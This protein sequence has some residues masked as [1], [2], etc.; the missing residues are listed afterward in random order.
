MQQILLIGYGIRAP[1]S[2]Q[3]LAWT[4]ARRSILLID[5]DVSYPL[6]V[7]LDAWPA[8]LANPDESYPLFLWGSISEMLADTQ[9][10]VQVSNDGPIVI[11]IAVLVTEKETERYWEEIL[12]GRAYPATDG[13]IKLA[14]EY[15]GFDVADRSFVSGLTNCIYSPEELGTLRRDWS[16]K[17]NKWGLFEELG[18]AESFRHVCDRLAPEHAPFEAYRIRKINLF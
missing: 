15:L 14:P 1:I 7:D 5:P 18:S 4:A 6:S 11:E 2:Q 17:T 12:Y 8:S 3:I 16:D 13:P 9:G 10:A